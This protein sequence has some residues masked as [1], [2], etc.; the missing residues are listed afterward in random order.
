MSHSTPRRAQLTLRDEA[1]DTP[2]HL[3]ASK[4][5]LAVVS[6]FAT[7]SGSHW[8][9]VARAENDR[10]LTALDVAQGRQVDVVKFLT[11]H[12]CPVGSHKAPGRNAKSK[13]KRRLQRRHRLR[14]DGVGQGAGGALAAAGDEHKAGQ[15]ASS[16]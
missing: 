12:G 4:G 16:T 7:A 1:G 13:A 3:A 9:D 2:L 5:K 6:A 8:P 10:G 11:K 14:P 15:Q